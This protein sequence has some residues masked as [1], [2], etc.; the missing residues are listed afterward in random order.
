MACVELKSDNVSSI[1][2]S[3]CLDHIGRL[4]SG[5]YRSCVNAVCEEFLFSGP[6]MNNYKSTTMA[7][8]STTATV[9]GISFDDD[10]FNNERRGETLVESNF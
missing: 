4:R 6:L 2:L 5:A 1:A 8:G 9:A 3:M 10:D 7:E